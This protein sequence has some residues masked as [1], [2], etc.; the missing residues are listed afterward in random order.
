MQAHLIG[1]ILAASQ[2]LRLPGVGDRRVLSPVAV[3]RLARDTNVP[4]WEIEALALETEVVPL[5]YLR[6]LARYGIPG[7]LQLARAHVAL[8]GSSDLLVRTAEEL[9]AAGVGRLKH[10]A[11]GA[12][13]PTG[14][15]FTAALTQAVRGK[16]N[17]SAVE[18]ASIPLRGGNPVE[19]VRGADVVI[20]VLADSA[21]EQ[22]LQFACRM[23]NA[24]LILGGVQDTQGQAT[25]V[26][27]G[28]PGVALVYRNSHLHLD[29]NRADF[30][31]DER[32]ILMVAAWLGEQALRLITSQGDLLRGRLLYADLNRGA[33]VEQPL[34]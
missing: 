21:E 12:S 27:P 6:H 30:A 14:E 31:A 9:A 4:R 3:E 7:Q 13:A 2:P 26:L 25:T 19:A 22:L 5:Q 11:P 15:A 32:A 23:A 8:V 24:P 34:S 17:S 16:N 18:T 29:P 33:I 28:D 1:D 10:L 20:G